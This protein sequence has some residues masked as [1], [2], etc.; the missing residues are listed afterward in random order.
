MW[1][2]LKFHKIWLIANRLQSYILL[3]EQSLSPCLKNTF[4]LVLY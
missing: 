1:F 4:V 2:G 3:W